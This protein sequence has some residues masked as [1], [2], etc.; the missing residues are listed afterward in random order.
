MPIS[1]DAA[2]TACICS[3]LEE[4]LRDIRRRTEIELLEDQRLFWRRKL[5]CHLRPGR[6]APQDIAVH[7]LARFFQHGV[8]VVVGVGILGRNLADILQPAIVIV[9]VR[10]RRSIRKGS[11]ETRIALDEHEPPASSSRSSSII[12]RGMSESTYDPVEKVN[13]GTYSS[14][15]AAP[16][17]F[18]YRSSTSVLIPASAR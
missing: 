14:E 13:P 6:R 3:T 7:D 9:P 1:P 17:I 4:I 12:L 5:S 15:I 2:T 16:P 10:K 8:V 18:E 11:E